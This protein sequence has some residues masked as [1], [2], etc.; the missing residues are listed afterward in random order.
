MV[1]S[2]EKALLLIKNNVSAEF[3]AIK[4]NLGNLLDFTNNEQKKRD[5]FFKKENENLKNS[6]EKLE[7]N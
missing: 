1:V 3:D 2:A 7:K 5:E 6:V 4:A